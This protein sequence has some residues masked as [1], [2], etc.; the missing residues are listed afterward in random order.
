MAKK[1][2]VKVLPPG[3]HPFRNILCKEK[4]AEG[5]YCNSAFCK[6]ENDIVLARE[7]NHDA[8]DL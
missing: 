5:D 3:L 8:K 2:E 7:P 1:I 6:L 4:C